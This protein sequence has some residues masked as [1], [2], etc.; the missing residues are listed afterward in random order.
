MKIPKSTRDRLAKIAKLLDEEAFLY[1]DGWTVNG[2]WGEESKFAQVK[3][4]RL[5]SAANFL[6][7]LGLRTNNKKA[8]GPI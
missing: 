1:R 2:E 4:I 6:R 5:E 7:T 3:T 8:D